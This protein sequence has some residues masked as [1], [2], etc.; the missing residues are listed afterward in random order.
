MSLMHEFA[1]IPK[2][3]NELKILPTMKRVSISDD[4]ILYMADSLKWIQTYWNGKEDKES[5]NYYGYS[6]I[7]GEN[8]NK[9]RHI[10]DNWKKL[11]SLAPDSFYITTGYLINE[12]HYEKT[13]IDKKKLIRLLDEWQSLCE[14]ALKENHNI[15]HRGV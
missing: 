2:E 5:L 8:L 11:F 3:Y 4:I 10:V 9:L 6:F 1:I 15:I 7:S 12:K 14:E 13:L